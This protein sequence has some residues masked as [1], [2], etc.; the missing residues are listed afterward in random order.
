MKKMNQLINAANQFT[1]DEVCYLERV[2]N[3]PYTELERDTIF[4]IKLT[5]L[6]VEE[7]F[8]AAMIKS[9]GHM[10]P[11]DLMLSMKQRVAI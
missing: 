2:H 10:N 7:C 11:I 4:A 6:V 8:K 5:E 9:N 3:R 1:D